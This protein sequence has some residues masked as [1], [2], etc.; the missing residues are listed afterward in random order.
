MRLAEHR[1]PTTHVGSLPRADEAL[2]VVSAKDYGGVWDADTF[3]Q[4]VTRAVDDVVHRQVATGL[5][6]VNDG[7]QSKSTTDRAGTRTRLA[8]FEPTD[9]P[10]GFTGQ[11][12]DAQQ[13]AAVYADQKVMYAARPHHRGREISAP[14]PWRVPT[15][16]AGRG[17]GGMVARDI[18][19]LQSAL[20]EVEAT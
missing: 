6:I 14:R 10:F 20:S 8:G 12:R 5:D 11:S 9:E 18:A 3:D 1:I 4:V 13:F 16:S 19:R 7:E 17:S 2:A 15:A